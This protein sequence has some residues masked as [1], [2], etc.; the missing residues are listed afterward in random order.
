MK[1]AFS[2]ELTELNCREGIYANVGVSE[3][4]FS[5]NATARR[6]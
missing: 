6:G 3:F 5:T 1:S 4:Q 2:G